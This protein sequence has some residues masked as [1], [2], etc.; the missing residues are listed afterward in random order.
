[1]L[2]IIVT[3]PRTT[4]AFLNHDRSDQSKSK[5]QKTSRNPIQLAP[6]STLTPPLRI[7]I[8]RKKKMPK[9]P[10]IP[11]I[12]TLMMILKMEIKTP[13]GYLGMMINIRWR[14]RMRIFHRDSKISN[15]VNCRWREI[16]KIVK[17]RAMWVDN[18][19]VWAM[20][21]DNAITT[22]IGREGSHICNQ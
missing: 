4:P 6:I 1:L 3:F 20:W 2:L 11:I 7:L 10:K 9:P 17:V 8:I 5:T 19:K 22:K 18:A 16:T 15:K 14:T 13:I 21:V 12:F